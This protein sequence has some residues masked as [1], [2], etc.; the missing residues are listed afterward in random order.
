[1]GVKVVKTKMTER[2]AQGPERRGAALLGGE[3]QH[4]EPLHHPLVLPQQKRT[5]G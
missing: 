2:E 4:T 5:R 3:K 1:M